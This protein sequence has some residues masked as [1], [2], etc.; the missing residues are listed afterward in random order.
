MNM[1]ENNN[2]NEVK[3]ASNTSSGTALTNTKVT[4]LGH[5]FSLIFFVPRQ[6][7]NLTVIIGSFI[8]LTKQS[9]PSNE[10]PL[11]NRNIFNLYDSLISKELLLEHGDSL[12]KNIEALLSQKDISE[13][14][15]KA[16]EELKSNYH[17]L[18]NSFNQTGVNPYTYIKKG[19]ME[20]LQ[21][22]NCFYHSLVELFKINDETRDYRKLRQE[23]VEF[24]QQNRTDEFVKILINNDIDAYNEQESVKN[25]IKE[26]IN[27]G[28]VDQYIKRS[29]E[30]G[31]WAGTSHFYAASMY[32]PIRVICDYDT[33]NSYEL[34]YNPNNSNL[35]EI[36][37]VHENRNH[38][39][40]KILT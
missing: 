1:T 9:E 23:V 16:L 32:R 3:I 27:A 29:A 25:G 11:K 24:L 8:G 40:P 15:K 26:K 35:N 31:F 37:I 34:S 39:N 18:K 36:T 20:V 38:F 10:N 33:P 17:F 19:V 13:N 12:E 30:N 4:A 22:G 28:D 14:T 6:L 5:I 7:W 21:D 2:V